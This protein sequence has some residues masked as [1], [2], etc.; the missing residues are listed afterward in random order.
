MLDRLAAR[1][2]GFV[3]GGTPAPCFGYAYGQ[4]GKAQQVLYRQIAENLGAGR[5]SFRLSTAL[6][7][8][9]ALRVLECVQADR[10]ELS[11]WCEGATVFESAG[12]RAIGLR[13]VGSEPPSRAEAREMRSIAALAAESVRGHGDYG[14]LKRLFEYVVEGSSYDDGEAGSPGVRARSHCAEGALLD[15]LAV[16]DGF[17]RALQMLLQA[18]G[19]PACRVCGTASDGLGRS[20]NHSW[21]AAMVEGRWCHV[22][23]TGAVTA[24]T[25]D[26]VYDDLCLSD[27]D[28]EGTHSCA[29]WPPSPACPGVP[30]WYDRE[31]C[32]LDS[33]DAGSLF[34]IAGRQFASGR[35][36]VSVKFCRP[37]PLDI[38]GCARWVAVRLQSMTGKGRLVWNSDPERGTVHVWPEGS[39]C[40][41]RR[42]LGVLT[43]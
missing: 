10:A 22:D 19:V 41:K 8:G 36:V 24:G 37:L 14:K 13:L 21:V 34:R 40:A 43:C 11:W 27:S 1:V 33:L 18:A 6:P 20:G 26:V 12:G 39:A 30:G 25:P 29:P 3:G 9:E 31:G 28:V 15:G 5:A 2:H 17:A 38:G 32:V 7:G 23:P 35:R 4:L 42:P 16:C